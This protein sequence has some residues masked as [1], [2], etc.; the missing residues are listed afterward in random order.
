MTP[1]RERGSTLPAF[2]VALVKDRGLQ[3]TVGQLV[4]VALLLVPRSPTWGR[5]VA[6]TFMFLPAFVRP[7]LSLG[8]VQSH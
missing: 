4:S 1:C 8:R 5:A 2:Y 7:D 3:A 6:V